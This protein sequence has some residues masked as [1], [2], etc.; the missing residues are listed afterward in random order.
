MASRKDW[1]RSSHIAP[2]LL[3]EL[4]P[5]KTLHRAGEANSPFPNVRGVAVGSDHHWGFARSSCR[6]VVLDLGPEDAL[7]CQTRRCRRRNSHRVLKQPRRRG[8]DRPLKAGIVGIHG[9]P[10]PGNVGHGESD[11]CIPLTNR[12]VDAHPWI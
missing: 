2:K 9:T 4:N 7:G 3:A 8:V 12:D 10:D 11:G 5:A 6:S 1:A